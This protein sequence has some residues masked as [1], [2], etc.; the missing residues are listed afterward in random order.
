MQAAKSLC[1]TWPFSPVSTSIPIPLTRVTGLI[2]KHS[3]AYHKITTPSIYLWTMEAISFTAGHLCWRVLKRPRLSVLGSLENASG[4]AGWHPWGMCSNPC[5]HLPAPH[6]SPGPLEGSAVALK[7]WGV[8]LPQ[9][10]ELPPISRAGQWNV[11]DETQA[12]GHPD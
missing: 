4:T 7:A 5:P 6:T 8:Y 1:E 10:A 12:S 3:I 11:V 2:Y 9:A